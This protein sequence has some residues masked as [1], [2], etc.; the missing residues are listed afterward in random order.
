MAR[1]LRVSC[2]IDDPVGPGERVPPRDLEDLANS[3]QRWAHDAMAGE[4]LYVAAGGFTDEFSAWASKEKR[5]H[6]LELHDLYPD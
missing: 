3:G 6:L 5:V 4:R 1:Y 2:R